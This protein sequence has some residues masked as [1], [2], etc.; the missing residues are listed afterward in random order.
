M[1]L[2]ARLL[3]IHIKKLILSKCQQASLHSFSLSF[4]STKQKK[5]QAKDVRTKSEKAD[6]PHL[7]LLAT[8]SCRSRHRTFLSQVLTSAFE[9]VSAE[10]LAKLHF[11]KLSYG[12]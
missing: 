2:G 5:D 11:L 9:M 10:V 6:A 12:A 1:G 3:Y 7:H 4:V 8:R